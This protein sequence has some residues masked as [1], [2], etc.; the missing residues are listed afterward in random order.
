MY[1][2]YAWMRKIDDI[3]D[4]PDDATAKYHKLAEFEQ[5]TLAILQPNLNENQLPT[6]EK[7]WLAFR[8]TVLDFGIPLQ[9]F[10]DMIKGQYQDIHHQFC[11]T[12]N[13]LYDYCY[14]VASTVGLICITIWG[15]DHSEKARELAISRGIAFQLTNILRDIYKDAQHK[16]IYLPAEYA[17][18]PLTINTILHDAP[19]KL[20]RAISR[21][22]QQAN[23]YYQQSAQLKK[24]LHPDGIACLTAMTDIYYTILQKIKAHPSLALSPNPVSLSSISKLVISAKAVVTSMFARFKFIF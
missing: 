15:Y 10:E 3:V 11:Q 2:I 23:H 22:A 9:Y 19:T 20:Q 12:F 24:H 21:L 14:R 4:A 8:Q 16:R 17:D 7:F 5:K 13:E 6:K 18:Q 1:A